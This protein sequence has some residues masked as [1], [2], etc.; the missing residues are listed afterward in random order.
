MEKLNQL[1]RKTLLLL[2]IATLSVLGLRA[3]N[4]AADEEILTQPTKT[5]H[6]LGGWLY[7]GYSRLI[8]DIDRTSVIGGI[9]AGIGVGYQLRIEDFLFKTGLEFEFINSSNNVKG[10]SAEKLIKYKD[11]I[12]PGGTASKDIRFRYKAIRHTD[13]QNVG[14]LNVPLMA[15]MRIKANYD[16]YFLAG[17]KVGLPVL[18]Y[19]VTN[20]KFTTEGFHEE[21]IDTFVNMKNHFYG[22]QKVKSET[23][24][25]KFGNI[26]LMASL[27]LG[28]EVNQWLDKALG[29]ESKST[30]TMKPKTVGKGKNK[31]QY[32]PF[33]RETPRMRAALFVDYGLMNI[34]DNANTGGEYPSEPIGFDESSQAVLFAQ[35]N[36]LTTNRAFEDGKAKKVV[37]FVVGVKGTVFFDV[38]KPKLAPA[39]PPP[40]PPPPPQL[41]TGKIV[42]LETGKEINN[43][44]VVMKDTT[45]KVL[46]S[47]AL[48][49]YGVFNTKLRRTGVYK[50][51][52]TVPNYYQY[53]RLASNVGDT[54]MIYIQPI[55]KGTTFVIKNIYFDFDKT[56]LTP[57]SNAELDKQAEFLKENPDIHILITGHTDSKGSDS[58]NMK[59]SE[60]RAIAVMN[61]LIERGIAPERLKAEGRGETQP[62][63][64]NDTEEGRAENRRIEIEIQ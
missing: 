40:P 57:E 27:E 31:R 11:P 13:G 21:Y 41:I 46:Y 37:P 49:N 63:A 30:K 26:N 36:L 59:L 1:T 61:A 53:S 44:R 58:Y 60:G 28:L 2:S 8:H 20:G 24:P 18:G 43:A 64:T 5:R 54:L 25:S 35:Q 23:H 15:G 6:Y 14:I 12:K 56:T 32:Q 62:V 42:D 51:E 3:Q 47:E 48:K 45:G 33:E 17:V 16:Y 52:V 4:K 34:N 9:G 19:N 10:L 39:P 29:I 50:V 38:T 22:V 55:K 7:T